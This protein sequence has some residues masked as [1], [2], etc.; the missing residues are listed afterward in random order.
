MNN[1]NTIIIIN[2]NLMACNLTVCSDLMDKWC[3]LPILVGKT[4]ANIILACSEEFN[5]TW[6]KFLSLY[7]NRRQ[8]QEANVYTDD[9]HKRTTVSSKKEKSPDCLNRPKGLVWRLH[10]DLGINITKHI[11]CNGLGNQFFFF[12]SE[13]A[14]VS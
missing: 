9:L 11:Q 6:Q 4:G 3:Y 10:T 7:R 8:C 13:Q 1:N 14:T 12:K 2:N 5:Q